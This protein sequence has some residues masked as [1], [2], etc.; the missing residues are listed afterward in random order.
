M[1]YSVKLVLLQG[2]HYS[3]EL[4]PQSDVSFILNQ[5]FVDELRSREAKLERKC[6]VTEPS[7]RYWDDEDPHNALRFVRWFREVSEGLVARGGKFICEV[8]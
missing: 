4:H 7:G 1:C 3:C 6:A 5:Q 8:P 2:G